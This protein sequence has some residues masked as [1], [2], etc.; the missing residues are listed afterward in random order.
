MHTH[1]THSLPPTVTKT[2]HIRVMSHFHTPS[3]ENIKM[4]VR[5]IPGR[6][7]FIFYCPLFHLN[8]DACDGSGDVQLCAV[9]DLYL[10]FTYLSRVELFFG[11][12]DKQRGREEK[13]KQKR[14]ILSSAHV[15]NWSVGGSSPVIYG[16]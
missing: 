1:K 10:C 6:R 15:N 11:R 5:I 8:Y 3:V 7:C 12:K 14:S 16:Q 4:S 2:Y 13:K 9:A